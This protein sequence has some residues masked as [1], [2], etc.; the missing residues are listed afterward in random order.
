[1]PIRPEMRGRYPA[2]WPAISAR[3]RERE[4]NR[5]KRCRVENHVYGYRDEDGAFHPLGLEPT[6]EWD[7]VTL[8]GYRIV[9]IVLTVAHLDHVPE[10]CAD[11]NLE[12]LCQR[13]HNGLDMP[14]RARGRKHRA[15]AAAGQLLLQ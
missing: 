8:D 14:T 13:C 10:H 1:M 15:E 2:D 4:G 3:I 6:Q 5:C 7:A 12:A 11:D 9:R